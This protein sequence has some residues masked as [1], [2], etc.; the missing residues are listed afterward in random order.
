MPA[1]LRRVLVLSVV[2]GAHDACSS[3]PPRAQLVVFIDTDAPV[4]SQI[5]CATAASCNPSLSPDAV[6]DTV[7]V[8][9]LGAN[10][11][12]TDVQTF[13]ASDSSSWPLSFGVVPGSAGEARLR[14]R[15]FRASFARAGTTLGR[16]TLDPPP[17]VTIE[18]LVHV[19]VPA[20]G[21]RQVSLFITEDCLGIPSRFD[22]PQAT[23]V[24]A[25]NEGGTP[26]DGV[27]EGSLDTARIGTWVPAREVPCTTSS[28]GAVC[29]PG[30]F[31]IL[32]ELS[33]AGA[34]DLHGYDPVPLRPVAVSPFLLD[35]H[36]YT[37]GRF[38]ALLARGPFAGE[39]PV[40][41]NGTDPV[42]SNFCTWLGPTNPA[43]DLLPLNCLTWATATLACM[44]DGGRLPSEAEWE[45]AARGRGRRL[46]HPWGDQ[47]ATCCASSL[48]RS[49][50]DT[51]FFAECGTPA[52]EPVGSHPGGAGCPFA[53]VTLDGAVDM[54]GSLRE[55]VADDFDSYDAPCWSTPGVP[56]D[57][58]CSDTNAVGKGERGASWVDH[59]GS[60]LPTRNTWVDRGL[61]EG[62]RCRYPGVSP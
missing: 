15:L 46:L 20:A 18:R 13:V 48:S 53:D 57:P 19:A 28:S 1:S 42:T 40:A 7:R 22:A 32:G 21:V 59:L 26:T 36:E 55:A 23:C 33:L 52:I 61:A 58:V 4:I 27:L 10:D 56:L 39:L 12:L 62:F 38:R 41:N 3:A 6:I 5:A 49:T 16:A 37:V 11:V 25:G 2:L 44:L 51:V 43:N 8:D 35:L 34:S 30:G 50:G 31:T 47:D 17:Q 29:I 60:E 54:N 14:I 45:H 9:V 24:D